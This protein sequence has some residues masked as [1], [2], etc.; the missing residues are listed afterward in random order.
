MS[1]CTHMPHTLR[2][3]KHT[4]INTSIRTNMTNFFMECCFQQNVSKSLINSLVRRHCWCKFLGCACVCTATK[5]A[6]RRYF[7]AH[8]TLQPSFYL[9]A[10]V[11]LLCQSL[12]LDRKLNV[13]CD[14]MQNKHKRI[15]LISAAY[16]LQ[17]ILQQTEY[18]EA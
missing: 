4:Y 13:K 2:S 9:W 17:R 1:T 18:Y 15:M 14:I 8:F 6:I 5:I 16:I 11:L 10:V 12:R 7:V 3:Q